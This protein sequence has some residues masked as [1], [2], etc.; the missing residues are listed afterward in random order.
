MSEKKQSNIY[1]FFI[2]KKDNYNNSNNYEETLEPPQSSSGVIRKN[3]ETNGG[4]K[5]KIKILRKYNSNYLKFGFIQEPDSDL[6]PRP[7][8]VVCSDILSNDAMKPS[9][10]ERHFQSKHKDLAN[11]PI[12]YFE[13]M[14]DD[15][16]KQVITMKKM[17]IEDKSLLKA[18]YLVAL[19][20]AKNKKPYTIGED[21]IKPCMLQAGEVVLGKQAVKK[22][23]EIPMSANTIKRRI[24]EMA[25]DIEN[26]VIIMVKN[27]PFYSIQLDE[28]TDVSNKALL[29]C[30]V[31]VEYG[32]GLQEELLCSLNLPGRTTSSEIFEAL[33]SYFQKHGIEWK[34]CIGI[35]TDGAANMVGH[36]SGI[37][38]KVK[39]VGHPDIL[40]T[41][42]ILH[43]EQLASK[44]MSPE[45]HEVLSD[46][47]KIVNNIRHKALNSRLF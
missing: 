21:L 35:C 29:L 40:S 5:K 33:D 4:E 22:L 10:L 37:V 25:D 1:N 8:C 43:R 16:R 27:S 28:S 2:N 7:L 46:V 45:L 11:K 12:E 47:I 42:C 38:A 26:Q 6:H 23:K 32:G 24:E 14:R 41:H 13:R 44:K 34:K 39:N 36:L 18:S 9:K 17:T 15:M 31:R 19:Q 20:I 30:F 3:I